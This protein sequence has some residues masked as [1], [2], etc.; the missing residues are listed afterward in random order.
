LQETT[1]QDG[2]TFFPAQNGELI[3]NIFYYDSANIG[4]DSAAINVGPDTSPE[5]FHFEN[6]L[7]YDAAS[8]ETSEP[9]AAHPSTPMGSIAGADPDFADA[10]AGDFSIAADSPAAAAG[11]DV[12][13]AA[14]FTGACFAT[15]PAVGAFEVPE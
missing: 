11:A 6:N 13:V 7:W 14:D 15:P 1:S 8:P 2:Y 5:T 4:S 12:A 10:S 3:N 9:V